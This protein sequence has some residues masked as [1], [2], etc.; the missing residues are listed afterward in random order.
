MKKKLFTSIK[1]ISTIFIASV[2]GLELW[3]IYAGFA[4]SKIQNLLNPVLW[5]GQI[6]IAIH[7]IEGLVAVVYAPS[8]QKQPLQYGIYTFFVGT[9][10][11]L[12][13]FDSDKE[14]TESNSL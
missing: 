13:L 9:V 6:A 12:E 2:L 4:G 1:W 11:L 3:K 8:K 7:F 10:G 14:A 5:L